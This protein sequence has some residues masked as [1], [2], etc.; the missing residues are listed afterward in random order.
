MFRQSVVS[1]EVQQIYFWANICGTHT[2]VQI[3]S[4]I[5]WKV[6]AIK[7]NFL[8]VRNCYSITTIPLNPIPSNQSVIKREW[9]RRLSF[10]PHAIPHFCGLV[11]CIFSSVDAV[12]KPRGWSSSKELSNKFLSRLKLLIDSVVWASQW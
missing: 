7:T 6:I 10:S 1:T 3:F 12:W 8:K 5:K 11:A 2:N 4:G 9:F